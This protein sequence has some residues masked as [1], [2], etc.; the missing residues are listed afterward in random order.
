MNTLRPDQKLTSEQRFHY[1]GTF[2]V[3]NPHTM[4]KK[5]GACRKM[6]RKKCGDEIV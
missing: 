4:M 3:F 5:N 2:S 1:E 6:Q